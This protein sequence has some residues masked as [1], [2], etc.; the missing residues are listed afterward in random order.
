VSSGI[1]ARITYLFFV[2]KGSENNSRMNKVRISR[3][4]RDRLERIP[5][6]LHPRVFAALGT[7]LV[8]NDVVAIIELVKNSYDAIATRVDVRFCT[9]PKTTNTII[10]IEDNGTGMSR[11]EIEDVWA[12]VATPHRMLTPYT[13]KGPRRRRVS[14]EKGLGRLSSARLGNQLEIL[15]RAE[16]DKCWQLRVDWPA[17]AEAEDISSCAIEIAQ[18][19]AS[20]S[21][22]KT[23]TLVRISD[24][25]SEWDEERLED[26]SDQLSRLVSPFE[27]V[28]DF[29]IWLTMSGKG[30]I[31]TRVVAP[32]FIAHPP[33]RIEGQV[34]KTGRL[35]A[36]YEF[37]GNK[38]KA[39]IRRNIWREVNAGLEDHEMRAQPVC[40]PFTFEIRAWDMDPQSIE[41]V[42]GAFR[43]A[44][45]AIRSSIR[46]YKGISVYRDRILV[47]PKSDSAKDWLGLDLRR[48]SRVGGRLSTSQLVGYTAITSANNWKIQD[49]SDRERLVENDASHDFTALLKRVVELL[50]GE[51]EKDRQDS[52]HREPPLQDL[53]ASLTADPLLHKVQNLAETGRTAAEALPLI[54][55]H[56]T[57][58]EHTRSEIE[59]RF[60]YYS[61]VASL[62][63]MAAAIV[64]EV[65][66]QLV[67]IGRLLAAIKKLQA[68]TTNSI[69]KEIGLAENAV[70]SL[71]R[72]ARRFAPLA[73]RS[74]PRGREAILEEI[75]NDC[76]AMRETDIA[77]HNIKIHVTPK[78]QTEVA[79]D[80]GELTAILIN[81]ID[82]AIYWLRSAPSDQRQLEFQLQKLA[83]ARIDVQVHDSG[84]GIAAGEEERIFW[85]GVTSKS[86]GLGM[87]LTVASELVSQHGGRTRLIVPGLL[88]GASFGFDLPLT[89]N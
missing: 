81:F 46:S 66:N 9:D 15:T 25:R 42:A 7:D 28:G 48:V 41:N 70:R 31:A 67:N 29:E 3:T 76:I 1:R 50:E 58:L 47:L 40:G 61:R 79:I 55:E 53:F 82:N 17:L 54:R 83:E 63:V 19:P 23:G 69:G 38:R 80:P 37:S 85:P 51:R 26:L 57:Q 8:T 71:E 4:D 84:P 65:R 36:R 21:I 49:T 64:H 73:T 45:S 68:A 77:A 33:Y 18:C 27:A 22:A 43:M 60:V 12:V 56:N 24:L 88:G 6:R 59:R 52:S 87:G 20:T 62:G 34:D 78:G 86:E 10:E 16:N 13:G 14:G 5:F 74:G 75:I 35:E 89:K 32:E 2:T 72:L 30:A 39:V 44:K 11:R